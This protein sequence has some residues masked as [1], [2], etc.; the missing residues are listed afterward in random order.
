MDGD[1]GV[2]VEVEVP[3]ALRGLALLVVVGAGQRRFHGGEADDDVAVAQGVAE[4]GHR[5]EVVADDGDR[6]VDAEAVVDQGVQVG[7]IGA[8]VVAVARFG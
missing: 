3:G 5:A 2:G 7:G 6:A 1:V 8:V 4:G